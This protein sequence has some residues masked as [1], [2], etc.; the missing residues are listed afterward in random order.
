M[1]LATTYLG[2]A[3]KNP[4]I[5]GASPLCDDVGMACQLEEAGAAMLVMGSLFQEQLSTD[6][7]PDYAGPGRS[8]Y[9]G[10]SAYMTENSGFRAAPDQYLRQIQKLKQAVTIPVVAS[11]NGRTA[12]EWTDYARLIE[13]AG[14]D[15]IEL[16][17][18]DPVISIDLSSDQIERNRLETVAA[19]R[20]VVKLPLAVKLSRTYTSLPHFVKQVCLAGASGIVMFN[21]LYQPAIGAEHLEL[22]QE[23]QLS[24]S[25]ELGTRLRAVAALAGRVHGDLVVTGGVHTSTDVIR[26]TLA[27]AS[28]VQ[29]VSALLQHGPFH[30]EYIL[31][32]LQQWLDTNEYDTL[33]QIRGSMSLLRLPGPKA[34]ERRNYIQTLN[35]WKARGS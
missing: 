10:A 9:A 31:K 6:A 1:A 5:V 22:Q 20:A 30:L 34:L 15:A 25:A 7:D 2:F 14:A 16:N 21:R 26:A 27:G 35:A 29:I 23:V 28:A 19:V 11:L 32:E 4:L 17:I 8:S 13:Q 12:G 3:L 33:S 24:T 18:Y